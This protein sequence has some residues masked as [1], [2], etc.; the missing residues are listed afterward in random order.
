MRS[1]NSRNALTLVKE[2]FLQSDGMDCYKTFAQ[3]CLGTVLGQT[4]S[5][6]SFKANLAK[7]AVEAASKLC[8]C[9]EVS[10]VLIKGVQSKSMKL[11]EFA[12]I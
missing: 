3:K 1:T 7:E 11:S 9:S 10:E 5:D 12:I 6:K 4:I 8:P 2:I